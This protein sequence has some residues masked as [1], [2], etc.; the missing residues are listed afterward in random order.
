[1]TNENKRYAL[2]ASL[3]YQATLTSRVYERRLEDR[4][5]KL[6]LSRLS[7]CLLL[8]VGEEKLNSPTEIASF[9]GI[10]RTSVSRALKGMEQDGL[11]S[12][13]E[14]HDDLRRTEVSL[15]SS[16]AALLTRAIKVGTENAAF[17]N[18]K[19]TPDEREQLRHLLAKLRD[20][21]DDLLSNF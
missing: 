8:A 20:G 4:L 19:L 10:D 9:I 1:M 13:S 2:H 18:A 21:E 11:L 5:R 12:R 16:G 15:T 14:R 3:G 6:G 17:F 7:W